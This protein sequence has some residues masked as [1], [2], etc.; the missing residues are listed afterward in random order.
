MF[1]G[2]M[3]DRPQ[4]FIQ[5]NFIFKREQLT[6]HVLSDGTDRYL[7]GMGRIAQQTPNGLLYFLPDALGMVP[8]HLYRDS[9]D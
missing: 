3:A 8:Y 5:G 1:P 2:E 4:L 9:W 6:Y 7:Y